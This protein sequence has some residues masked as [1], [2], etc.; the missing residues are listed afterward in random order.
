MSGYRVDSSEVVYRGHLGQVRVDQVRMPDGD[1]AAREVA[2]HV[3]AVGVVPLDDDGRVVLVRQYRHPLGRHLLEIP[4][5]LLDV[6]GEGVEDAA[7]RELAEE[8]GLAADRLERLTRFENSAGW[9]DE[10]TTVFL[11]TGLRE[12][13]PGDGFVAEHEEAAMEIV[14]LPLA[15]AVARVRSGEISDAKTIVGLLLAAARM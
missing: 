5:G 9:S 4:A 6:E 14:R 8:T 13:R 11:A 12:Q 10:A 1:T 3:D 2:E 7:R 15:D